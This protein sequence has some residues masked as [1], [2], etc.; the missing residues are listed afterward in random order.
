MAKIDGIKIYTANEFAKA[1]INDRYRMHLMNPEKYV[2]RAHEAERFERLS[3]AFTICSE[4]PSQMQAIRVLR[5]STDWDY[6]AGAWQYLMKQ[7]MDVFGDILTSNKRISRAIRIERLHVY[8]KWA[9]AKGDIR[10]AMDCIMAIEK[11]EASIEE[12]GEEE[13]SPELVPLEFT[14]DAKALEEGEEVENELI[15]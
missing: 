3:L 1:E 15:G 7:C 2:L 9:E 10:L 11:I 12:L 14:T 5:E 6:S 4:W 13:I 8:N